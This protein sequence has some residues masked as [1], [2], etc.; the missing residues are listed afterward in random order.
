VPSP[1][2]AVISGLA[3]VAATS[4]SNAWAV[5]TSISVPREISKTLILDWNGKTWKQVPS[6]SPSSDNI[7]LFGV[8]ATSTRD[9]WA[10]GGYGQ[11]FTSHKALILHWNG[12]AW[13]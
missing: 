10:V 11:D 7:V 4:A 13:K 9:S 12:T 3:G 6:P 5:G 8:A 1:S 2:P